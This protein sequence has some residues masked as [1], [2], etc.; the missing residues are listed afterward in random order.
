MLLSTSRLNPT[1]RAIFC[2][3][4]HRTA[5][6]QVTFGIERW[7]TPNGRALNTSASLPTNGKLSPE[8]LASTAMPKKSFDASGGSVFRN[9]PDAAK[10]ALICAAA[11]IQPLSRRKSKVKTRMKSRL[12]W[13]RF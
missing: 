13:F 6:S 8:L 3:G 7:R 1:A 11:S 4:F 2:V 10:G 5:Q 9:L 12:D